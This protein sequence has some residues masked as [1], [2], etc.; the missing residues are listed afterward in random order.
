MD[1]GGALAVREGRLRDGAMFVKQMPSLS[2]DEK[3]QTKRQ[4]NLISRMKFPITTFELT[5]E[6]D[7]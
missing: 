4:A 1:G 7:R 2:M 3:T 5:N 6:F